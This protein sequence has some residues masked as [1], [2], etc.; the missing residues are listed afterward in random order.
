MKV[1]FIYILEAPEV[2]GRS[3]GET[4]PQ[5]DE[6]LHDAFGTKTGHLISRAEPNIR[7]ASSRWSV[8]SKFISRWVV[9]TEGKSWHIDKLVEQPEQRR[10]YLCPHEWCTG[11]IWI[12]TLRHGNSLFWSQSVDRWPPESAISEFDRK[13]PETSGIWDADSSG[14]RQGNDWSVQSR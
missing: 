13:G 1:P 7:K 6:R 12:K 2:D 14:G 4:V 5:I 8:S 9:D 10:G 3:Y 11:C